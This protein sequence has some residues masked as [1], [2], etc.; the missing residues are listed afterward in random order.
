MIA[1]RQVNVGRNVNGAMKETTSIKEVIVAAS[2]TND[3]SDIVC[4]LRNLAGR[5]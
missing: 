2:L 4:E 1:V 3:K 5:P